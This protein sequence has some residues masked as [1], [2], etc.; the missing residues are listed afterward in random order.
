[1]ARTK[2]YSLVL[3]TEQQ[4]LL[5]ESQTGLLF[6]LVVVI[7]V[8]GVVGHLAA[9]FKSTLRGRCVAILVAGCS[10]SST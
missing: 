10:G 7:E 4:D 2:T 5:H 3:E 1:M 6:G 8:A 9:A